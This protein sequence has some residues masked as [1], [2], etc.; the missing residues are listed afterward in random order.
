MSAAELPKAAAKGDARTVKRL[1]H[2][3]APPNSKGA[4]GNTALHL[5]AAGGHAAVVKALLEGK[6]TPD[7][8]AAD[9]KWQGG[10]A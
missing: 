9:G 4:H 7:L 10:S 2:A 8:H 5:A 3:G 1:L 6:A